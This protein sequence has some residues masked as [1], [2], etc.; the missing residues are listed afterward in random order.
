MHSNLCHF[1]TRDCFPSR[2]DAAPFVRWF[3]GAL[4]SAAFNEL[5]RHVL[6]GRGDETAFTNEPDDAKQATCVS[7]RQ[8]LIDS[9]LAAHSLRATLGVEHGSRVAIY[10][11]NDA[12]AVVWIG[13][14]KRLGAPYTAVAAETASASLADRLADTGAAVLVTGGS[15]QAGAVL[16]ALATLPCEAPAVVATAGAKANGWLDASALQEASQEHIFYSA[17]HVGLIDEQLVRAVA[18]SA[19]ACRRIAPL[20]ICTHRAPRASRVSCTRTGLPGGLLMTCAL[21]FDLQPVHDVLFVWRRPVGSGQSYMIAA[22]LLCRVPSVLLD[23]SPV[24][25]PGRF[26]L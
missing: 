18:S 17:S 10:L 3:V 4:T 11:P 15:G 5:D 9:A 25:P 2:Q 21:V 22:P 26:A 12:V 14:A 23:G 24:S 19:A 13:A 8:L 20:F 16:E 1:L 6:S 7:K